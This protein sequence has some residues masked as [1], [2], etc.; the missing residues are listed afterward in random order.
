MR[1]AW[2]EP[3]GFERLDMSSPKVS[4][5]CLKVE[6]LNAEGLMGCQ[7]DPVQGKGR[8]LYVSPVG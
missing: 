3:F 6:R 7:F 2:H 8:P 5:T 1:P 4:L